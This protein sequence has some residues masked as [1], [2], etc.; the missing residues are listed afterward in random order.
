MAVYNHYKRIYHASL[1]AGLV[2]LVSV[3]S[4]ICSIV[5]TRHITFPVGW[6]N[7]SI[8]LK[9]ILLIEFYKLLGQEGSQCQKIM[10]KM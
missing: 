6:N 2:L 8:A 1:R 7:Y 5:I 10:M 9:S 3:Y 4:Y